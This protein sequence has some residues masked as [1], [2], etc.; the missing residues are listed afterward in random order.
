MTSTGPIPARVRERPED[1]VVEEIP[2]DYRVSEDGRFLLVRVTV[3]NWE[4]N[5]LVREL[6]RRLGISRRR[7]SFAG[8][9]DKRAVT[10]QLMSFA[11]VGR[12]EI[13]EIH[14]KDVRLEPLARTDRALKLG[15]HGG[16]RFSILLRGVPLPA[17]ETASRL[18]SL[19]SELRAQGGFPNF[20]G[21]QRFGEVRPITHLVGRHIV[22]QDIRGAVETYIGLPVPG[23]PSDALEARR[24]YEASRDV[25]RALR[26]YPSR[27]S[28]ERA[29]LNY[30]LKNPEDHLGALRQLPP[31]L[32]TLFVYAYQ[33][34]LFNRVLSARLKAG[35]G[36]GPQLG[37]L[38]VAVGRRGQ[39]QRDRPVE[40]RDSNLVKV[41]KQ[42][43]EGKAWT[44]GLV[45]GY[46]VSLAGGEMGEL[47]RRVMEE[48]GAKPED[49]IIRAMPRLSSRGL[50][51][52]L[53]APIMDLSRQ[54]DGG[55]LLRFRL[56]PG[57]YAT[58][59][60]RELTKGESP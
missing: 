5:R 17:A 14:L 22:N 36:L 45:P 18:D 50:R 56:N 10:T 44:T 33:S 24:A 3:R 21:P 51:R 25:G 9:K 41:E 29:M 34:Y 55:V 12:E 32:L 20:F 37:D 26:E 2:G 6:S 1:F 27:L 49:F 19:F 4:T 52:E 43:R 48:E 40:V 57:S 35:T 8:T 58:A 16:N 39:P 30:L 47:E 28:F 23:E 54:V 38:V 15:D 42:V 60:L 59:L 53:I 7:I 46:E 13:E 31:N 11:D